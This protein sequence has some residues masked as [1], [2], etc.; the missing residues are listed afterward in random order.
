MNLLVRIK[1]LDRFNAWNHITITCY[2]DSSIV[3]IF[4]G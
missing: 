4:H 2:Q 3:F 1:A